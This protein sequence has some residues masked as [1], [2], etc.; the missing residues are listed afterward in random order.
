LGVSRDVE[1]LGLIQAECGAANGVVA[2]KNE[3]IEV[4]S[5]CHSDRPRCISAPDSS[6]LR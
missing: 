2:A 5:S 1:L 3:I 4:D 6:D